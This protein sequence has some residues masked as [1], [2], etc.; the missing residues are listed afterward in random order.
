MFQMH[1]EI[2]SLVGVRFWHL[3]VDFDGVVFVVDR[4]KTYMISMAMTEGED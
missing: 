3:E 1:L 2:F 4:M